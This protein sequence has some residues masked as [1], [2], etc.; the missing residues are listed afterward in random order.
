MNIFI[1]VIA[2]VVL[3]LGGFFWFSAQTPEDSVPPPV[4][5]PS[6]VPA[7]APAPATPP[8]GA[9]NQPSAINANANVN[10]TVETKTVGITSYQYSPKVLTVK[11]GTKVTWTNNDTV[12]HTVT[13]TGS[14]GG[15]DS[16]LFGQN[17]SY[18]F[19]FD[20]VGTYEYYC[21]PHPYMKGTVVV[22]N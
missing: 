16:T 1:A 19:T 22:T 13:A 15:P 12:A 6:P 9:N 4:T 20:K 18:S 17:E 2:A 8:A 7:P 10:V 21:K 14:N 5:E 11:V 3:G